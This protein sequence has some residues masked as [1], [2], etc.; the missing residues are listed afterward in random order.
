MLFVG[1]LVYV[2]KTNNDREK[3][4]RN[5]ISDLR[6]VLLNNQHM[7]QKIDQIHDHIVRNKRE[8]G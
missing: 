2:M 7:E 8:V 6:Q 3:N 4:Y 5:T 1:L